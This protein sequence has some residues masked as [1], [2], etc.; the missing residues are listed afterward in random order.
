MSF[1]AWLTVFVVVAVFV[2]LI[3][4]WAPT[5]LVFV[6][7]AVFL[8]LAGIIT[9]QETFAGFSNQGVLMVAVLFIVAAGLRETGVLEYIGSFLLATVRT[10][11]GVLARLSLVILPMSAFLNNTPIVAM[12]M[13]MLVNWSRR[14]QISP[15][16]IL[17]PLSYLAILGGTCTLIGTSTNLVVH[18]LMLDHQLAGLGMFEISMVGVPYALIGLGYLIWFGPRLLPERKE[19]LEQLSDARREYLI[20]VVVQPEYRMIGKT[21]EAAGL[22]SLPGLFLIEIGREDRI[23]GPVRPNDVI[24]AGDRLVFTGIV[25]SIVELQQIPGLVPSADPSYEVTPKQQRQRRICEAVISDQSPLNGKTI[26]EADFRAHY[27]AAVV[28]VHRG[29]A[30]LEN[31]IGDIRLRAGDTLLLQTPPHFWRA[32]HND[33]A[34]FLI[35]DLQQWRPLRRDRAGLALLLFGILVVLLA[36]EF[37]APAIAAAAAAVLMIALGCVSVSDARQSIEWQV[38]VT[39]AAALAIGIALEKTGAASAIAMAL[40]DAT[41]FLGPIAALAI[42][43]ILVSV[44]T[45]LITNNAAAVMVFPICLETAQIY[46]VSSRPFLIALVLAASASFMTPIG[47]QTN[48][49]VYGPGGYRFSDYLRV[50]GPLNLILWCVAV[51]LVPWIWPFQ[52]AH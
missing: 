11:R 26:R 47:Y 35:S 27:G 21:I 38:L 7:A 48:L 52:P 24:K 15:S 18:G 32:H 51:L 50:G 8:T 1:D 17:I 12:F 41:A 44:A 3:R 49:M 9:P 23:I 30:R 19:L 33:S 20:E 40:V 45:E 2:V 42:I 28:A 6:A 36:G 46:D 31:K 5:D 10:E 4:E 39:I 34:F 22:R 37:V 25:S 14:I 16:K 29:G 13:P 43:Y